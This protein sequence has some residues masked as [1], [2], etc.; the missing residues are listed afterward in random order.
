MSKYTFTVDTG[1][2]V[3]ILASLDSYRWSME[4]T[5]ENEEQGPNRRELVK[6]FMRIRDETAT[7]FDKLTAEVR[8]QRG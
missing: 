2:A 5:I 6:E 8:T 4:D 7:L 3:R 1:E